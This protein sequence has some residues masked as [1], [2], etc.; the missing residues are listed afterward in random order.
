MDREQ[1]HHNLL[2]R[3]MRLKMRRDRLQADRRRAVPLSADFAEQAVERENDEALDVLDARTRS[4][5]QEIELALERIDDA[6]FG[7]CKTCGDPISGLRLE[8][9]PATPLCSDCATRAEDRGRER[10]A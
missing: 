2:R 5:L 3:R 10:G 9:F 4:D 6:N 8:F 7:A 1:I